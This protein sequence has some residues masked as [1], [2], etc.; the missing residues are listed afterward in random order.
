MG[1]RIHTKEN[2]NMRCPS[3]R[4]TM[5]KNATTLPY[6][7][8]GDKLIVVRDVPAMVCTQCGEVFIES[9]VLKK[10]EELLNT[11][12]RSGMTLGFLEYRVAA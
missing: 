7:L 2:D 8:G 5:E 11:V 1:R 12:E 3:C 10:V 4:G 9:S 6:E